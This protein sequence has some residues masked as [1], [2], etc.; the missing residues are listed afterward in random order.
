MK[1]ILLLI[2]IV[3]LVVFASCKKF[4]E[5]S[6]PSSLSPETVFNTSSMA[7]AAVMGLYGRMTDAN[8][9]GQK[10]SVNW[11][12][13]SDIESNGSFSETQYNSPT[14]D[15]GAGNF[16]GDPN[17]Q[18][19]RWQRLYE[20]AEMSTAV[21]DGIR[22][23]P[24]L[25]SDAAQMMPLLGE[26]LT[27]KSL[28]FFELT[29]Y[30]GDVPY[31]KEASKSDLTNVYM[32]KMDKDTVYHYLIED[33]DEAQSYLPWKG[34]DSEYSTVERITKG[35][36][37]GLLARVA[38]FAGGWSLRDASLFP[39]S[40]AERHPSIPEVNGYYVGRPQNWRDYY[41][42]AVQHT[43]EMLGSGENPHD[44]DPSFQ[45]IWESVCAGRQS[46]Y[47]ENLFE[48]AFGMGNN[49]DI[50]SLMGY[51]VAGNSRY[52]TRGFGG[53]YVTSTA[54]YFY[55]FDRE[56]QRRD[57]TLTWLQYTA[58]NRESI[59]TNP[60]DVKLGKWRIYWMSD[61]YLAMHRTATS[62]IATGV[63]WILMRYSDVYLMYA[64]ALS[65]LEGP[66]AVHQS[67]GISARQA[68]EKVRERAF[69]VGSPNI[70]TYDANFLDAIIHERA[71]EFGGESIRKQDLVRW[72]LLFD[73]IEDMKKALCLM[74]DNKQPVK[75]F[76]KTYQPTDFPKT[77][78]YRFRN[79]EYID[80]S[81]L[82]YYGDLPAN[83]GG[84][85]LSVNWFPTA[86]EKPENVQP[87]QIYNYTMWPVRVLLAGTGLMASY[88]YSSFLSTL[89]YGSEIQS[90]LN[91]YR[92]G[93]GV[94]NYRYPFPI[95]VDDIRESRGFL[96]NAYG[97]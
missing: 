65:Q 2:S 42:I 10:L 30:W 94:C 41:Q 71:W 86:A 85:Y 64:E 32:G 93:N 63:N 8:I 67:A 96:T 55:S 47:N 53:S 58:E 15:Y 1:K 68:L 37:K 16:F 12:G 9:Y 52:G 89:T 13:V 45:N 28:A 80:Q 25:E 74:Y 23:S 70:Y 82:N 46:T 97:Y 4:L 76:D 73:K 83:P 49:G 91:Q 92:M 27:L 40:T 88:D 20:F 95:Y 6:S 33:L 43:A 3:S 19:T 31:K 29:R 54:Y 81:S 59:S 84:D 50:G 61:A 24:I 51:G 66:D 78:Y 87:G 77:V 7:K 26:A 11:Q 44:L 48:I 56:D 21:V 5:T 75:I 90:L 18:T 34:A 57:V 14:S 62:R 36:A 38:L 69:G 60:N 35:F 72:G 22:N 39:N 79:A 17:N